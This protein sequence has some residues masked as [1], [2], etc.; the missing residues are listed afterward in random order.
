MNEEQNSSSS[1]EPE[2][3]VV[4]DSD[5]DV[6]FLHMKCVMDAFT[7]AERCKVSK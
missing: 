1:P 6:M 2:I 7:V 3:E 4:F 5:R